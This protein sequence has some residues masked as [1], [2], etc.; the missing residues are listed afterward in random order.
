MPRIAP[1]NG[2][3]MKPAAGMATMKMP[4]IRARC[5]AGNQ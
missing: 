4:T 5:A 3:P 2:E 1:D